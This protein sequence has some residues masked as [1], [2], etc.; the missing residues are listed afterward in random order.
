M[1]P[2]GRTLHGRVAGF[3]LLEILVAM[4]V[5]AFGLLSVARVLGRSSQEELEAFQRTQAISLVQDMA[6]RINANRKNAA[7]YVATY[8]PTGA[9]EDC[10]VQPTLAERDMCQWRN[11]LRGN[12]VL[13]G[14]NPLGAPM[15]ARGCVTS[16]AANVYIVALA[17]QGVLATGAP[18]SPCG[19][20]AF[21]SEDNRRVYSIVMQIA[22]LGT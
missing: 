13:D 15:S 3:T 5:L 17:W 4:L 12:E 9:A 8:A 1:S 18:D 2:G 14:A 10:T 7:A 6:D 22:Q 19:T 11:R 21:S 20:G 16:P